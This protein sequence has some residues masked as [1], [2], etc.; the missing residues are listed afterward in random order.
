[1]AGQGFSVFLFQSSSYALRA[2]KLLAQE[3][4]RSKLIPVPRSLSSD[5]GVCLR[6]GR[7]DKKKAIMVME[8]NSLR[9]EQVHDLK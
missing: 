7:A 8:K 4:I 2:E 6:T 9:F 5:C 1:M 3:K